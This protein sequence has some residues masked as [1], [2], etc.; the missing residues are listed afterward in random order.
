MVDKTIILKAITVNMLSTKDEEVPTI[1]LF[2]SEELKPP[3]TLRRRDEDR[4]RGVKTEQQQ[5]E[6]CNS[7]L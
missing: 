4:N 1:W 5:I 7:Q 3:N 6:T 2:D